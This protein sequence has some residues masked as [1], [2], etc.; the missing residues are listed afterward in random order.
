MI[1][2]PLPFVVC[3]WYQGV[4]QREEWFSSIHAAHYRAVALAQT[5]ELVTLECQLNPQDDRVLIHA[6]GETHELDSDI[7]QPQE[8]VDKRRQPAGTDLGA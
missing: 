5:A 2:Y 1:L 8:A 3:T 6:Y 4:A 7:D